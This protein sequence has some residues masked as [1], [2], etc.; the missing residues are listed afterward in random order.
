MRRAIILLFVTLA[1]AEVDCT[2]FVSDTLLLDKLVRGMQLSYLEQFDSANKVIDEV[3][4]AYPDPNLEFFSLAVFYAEMKHDED[5]RRQAEFRNRV[6]SLIERLRKIEDD[7][8]ISPEEKYMLGMSYVYLA[9]LEFDLGNSPITIFRHFTKGLNRLEEA[10]E[11]PDIGP[12]GMLGVGTYLY[13]KSAKAGVLRSIGIVSDDRER[14]IRMLRTSSEE[15]LFSQWP[16]WH[17]LVVAWTDMGDYDSADSLITYLMERDSTIK[18]I[19]WDAMM[20]EKAKGNTEGIIY[21]GEYLLSRYDTG[22]YQNFTEVSAIVAEAYLEIG[23]TEKA[24]QIA[25]YALSKDLNPR[26]IERQK[27]SIKVL[28][29]IVGE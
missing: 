19:R 24:K 29:G 7:D 2:G 15:S 5:F 11:D 13:F 4:E 17:G 20:L 28:E 8:C 1:F 12:E 22:N 14:G 26:V 25:D 3:R 23:N 18:T 6:D 16:A 27:D 9:L 10:A 21:H